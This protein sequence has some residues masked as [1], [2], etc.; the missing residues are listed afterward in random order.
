LIEI[1]PGIHTWRWWSEEKQLDFNGHAFVRDAKLFVVDPPPFGPGDREALLKLGTPSE[2]LLTNQHHG[3]ASRDLRR[4]FGAR[5]W[6]HEADAA[7][8][9][10]PPDLKFR[11]DQPLPGGV[12]ALRVPDNKTPGECALWV[13]H[14]SSGVLILG[15][16]LIGRPKGELSLLPAEKYRDLRLARAGVRVLLDLPYEALL[17]GDGESIPVGGRAALERFLA[18][19]G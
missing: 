9:A 19:A 10:E 12:R 15:D 2:I 8:L 18:A 17:V 16:A 3:R 14:G 13:P 6:I 11:D 4:E 5:I 7:G 1:L